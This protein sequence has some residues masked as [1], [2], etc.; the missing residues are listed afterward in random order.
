MII[1]EDIITILIGII[2]DMIRKTGIK[3]EV[4]IVGTIDIIIDI[5]G[6]LDTNNS[7]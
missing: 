3:T 5:T 7:A 1:T 4:E 2:A 6:N